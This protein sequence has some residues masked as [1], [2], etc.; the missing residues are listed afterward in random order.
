MPE[1]EIDYARIS[2]PEALD[3]L[4]EKTNLD[5]DSYI[6]GQGIVQDVAFTVAAAKGQLLQDIRDA[7]DRSISRGE[8]V[9][10]FLVRFNNIAASYTDDWPL[11]GGNSWR[12]A[13][14]YQ[15]NIRQAYNAGRYAQMTDPD[16]IKLR[17]Y[18]QWRHGGSDAPR[19]NHLALDGRVF[20]A[21]SLPFHPPAGFS[22]S[23]SV[24]SLSQRDVDRKG[25]EVEG[26]KIGDMLDV[27]DP[28]DG[29]KKKVELKPDKGFD[30]IPGKSTPE[31]R[32][33]LLKR[34]DPELRK[35]VERE[36]GMS[37]KPLMSKAEAEEYTKDSYYEGQDFYHGTDKPAAD[38]IASEGARIESESVNTYGE[39]FY[40]AFTKGVAKQ[41]ASEKDTPTILTARVNVKNPRK[42]RDSIDFDD[43]LKENSIP[44]DDLQSRAASKVLISQGFDAVE[45]GGHIILVIIFNQTQIAIFQSEQL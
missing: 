15:Q 37:W 17:P 23:C 6:E 10:K 42:F 44:A 2:F 45:I 7:M 28:S 39:G 8:S 19:L 40:F 30:R 5:T 14:I 1:T 32:A 24:F 31:Q 36:A 27:I 20:P 12:G 35:A 25:L 43:F 41:Y 11:K 38:G 26:L 13:L 16:V 18:W 9:D 29:K 3:Y 22:C 34:L 21:D 4:S 33:N